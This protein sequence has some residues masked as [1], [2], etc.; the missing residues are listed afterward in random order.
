MSSSVTVSALGLPGD[1]DPAAGPWTATTRF[2]AV[3][4]GLLILIALLILGTLLFERL[5]RRRKAASLGWQR[6]GRQPR[7]PDHQPSHAGTPRSGLVT[8][9]RRLACSAALAGCGVL[10]A[11][12]SASA[13]QAPP[14]KAPAVVGTIT[15]CDAKGKPVT[16]G[17]T[18][19]LPFAFVAI[20]SAP[21]TGPYANKQGK[22]TLYAYQPR[23]EIDPVDWSGLQLSGSSFYSTTK[24]PAVEIT[25]GDKT[26]SQDVAN[27]PPQ[28]D[29]FVQLRIF[30]SVPNVGA[31]RRHLPRREPQGHRDHVGRRRPR[32]HTL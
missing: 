23:K 29:G 20:S 10:A 9:L 14:Y 2:W 22:A 15:L 26:I 18:R 13:A 7:R 16:Q 30:L 4:W 21:A 1:V 24:H 6:R 11:A 3:P 19:D 12:G 27:F 31:E 28:W 8:M 25:T 17:D 32:Q 5:R